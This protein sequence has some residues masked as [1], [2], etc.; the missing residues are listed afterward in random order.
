[1]KYTDKME[2]FKPQHLK[3]TKVDREVY[4]CNVMYTVFPVMSIS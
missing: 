1:V 4:Y 3:R 2:Q